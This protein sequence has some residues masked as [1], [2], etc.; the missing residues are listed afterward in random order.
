MGAL[1]DLVSRADL[2]AVGKANSEGTKIEQTRAFAEVV[3]QAKLAK[4]FPRSM[5][6][7]FRRIEE[8]FELSPALLAASKYSFPRGGAS[9]TG[10]TIQFARAIAECVGNV[11]YSIKEMAREDKQSEIL[12]YAW[13]LE[14]NTM[15]TR[16]IIVPHSRDT[17]QGKKQLLDDRDIYENNT[18]NGARR[19][20]ECILGVLPAA[21]VKKGEEVVE[22]LL[23]KAFPSERQQAYAD[24]NIKKYKKIGVTKAMLTA[25]RGNKPPEM[26]TKDDFAALDVHWKNIENQIVTV[27]EIFPNAKAPVVKPKGKSAAEVKKDLD[28]P[29]AETET[30]TEPAKG[31]LF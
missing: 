6:D 2:S 5:V 23:K 28:K 18:N 10:Y 1:G 14:T 24:G 29:P 26:W 13:D 25:D 7:V 20:R 21:A 19:L 3:V 22:N 16:S 12:T 31:G 15:Q 17:K 30:G 9:V 4:E 8:A 27:G 11:H